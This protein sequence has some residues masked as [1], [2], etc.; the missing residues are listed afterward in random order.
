MQELK[1][2]N[3][4]SLRSHLRTHGFDTAG[5]LSYP[6]FVESDATDAL[7]DYMVR[8]KVA[9]V[10]G[11]KGT[12]RLELERSDGSIWQSARQSRNSCLLSQRRRST[13]SVSIMAM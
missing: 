8:R 13:T 5:L 1:D 6:N 10:Q 3:I 2:L 9:V 4:W 11:L 7:V 12:V